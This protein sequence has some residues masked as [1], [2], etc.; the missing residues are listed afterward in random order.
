LLLLLLL[1][2]L[3][4]LLMLLAAASAA[5]FLSIFIAR[6]PRGSASV[7]GLYHFVLA[8]IDGVTA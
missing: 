3:L 5:V 4:L 2:L 1:S 6:V 7:L 8:P